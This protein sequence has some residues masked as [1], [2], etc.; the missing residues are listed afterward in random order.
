MSNAKKSKYLKK[1]ENS[2][3]EKVDFEVFFA[4]Q[5]KKGN[6]GFWQRNEILSFF[7]QSGLSKLEDPETYL[8]TLKL[9]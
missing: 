9:Y 5:V 4:Q 3:V 2:E 1:E 6:L 8:N 7:K